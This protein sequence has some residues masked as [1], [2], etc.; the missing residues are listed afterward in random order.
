[1][2]ALNTI[3]GIIGNGVITESYIIISGVLEYRENYGQF[4]SAVQ[5]AI[6]KACV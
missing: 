1:L 4:V 2:S 6:L 5:L 3:A